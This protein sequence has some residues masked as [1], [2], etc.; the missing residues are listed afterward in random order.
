MLIFLAIL[1]TPIV[2]LLLLQWKIV[3]DKIRYQSKIHLDTIKR[4]WLDTTIK[5]ILNL[6]NDRYIG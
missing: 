3:S 5:Y 1:Y 4:N 6:E 2:L